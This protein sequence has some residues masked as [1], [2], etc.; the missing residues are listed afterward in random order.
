MKLLIILSILISSLTA[1]KK[2]PSEAEMTGRWGYV[3][4]E[5]VFMDKEGPTPDKKA[6][7]EHLSAMGA[8]KTNCV[9]SFS[10]NHK[11]SLK[12]GSKS[13]DFDW[14]L[15][16]KT[17]Q[18]KATVAMVSIKG[19]MVRDGKRIVLVFKRSDLFLIMRYLCNSTGRK[20]IA[21]LG[22]LLDSTKGLTLA[23]A[24]EASGS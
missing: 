24:F 20:H 1:G 8:S 2:T 6:V 9:V 19:Y 13:M 17:R 23:M 16:A 12:L 7:D 22:E 5:F 3:A 11:G 21:P 18:F 15:D 14:T 10:S 4:N